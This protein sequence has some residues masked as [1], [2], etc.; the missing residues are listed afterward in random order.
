LSSIR[1]NISLHF[2]DATDFV[3]RTPNVPMTF[4]GWYFFI[5]D[6][7][8]HVLFNCTVSHYFIGLLIEN[9]YYTAHVGKWHLGGMTNTGRIEFD[10]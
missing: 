2:I 7:M 4:K 1:N 8:K 5:S 10:I 3:I 6:I 9:G